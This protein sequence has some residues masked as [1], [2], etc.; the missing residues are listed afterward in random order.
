VPR[1][2]SPE[3]YLGLLFLCALPST[4]QSSI[5]FTM[6]A[7]GNVPAAVCAASASSL[8]GIVVTP[9]LVGLLMQVHGG[10][11]L[12]SVE[13]IALQLLAP[14]LV[15][16]FARRWIGDWL[17]RHK[18]LTGLVDRGVILLIVYTAFSAGVVNG[19]WHEIDLR[20]LLAVVVLDILLL[21]LVLTITTVVSRRLGFSREDEIAI[22]FCGSKK[23]LASGI[24][25]AN[26]LF[27][28]QAAS[29][30]VL[31]LILFHQIQ[32]MAC[33]ALAQSY[34]SRRDAKLETKG[35]NLEANEA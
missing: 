32:L 33:A 4:V 19:I 7:G 29:L 5:V 23:S 15:G 30:I 1:I 12:S 13:G 27:P 8:I 2:L 9:L 3:L 10:V 22:V 34:A 16:Q 31:P 6:I 35:G 14:F 18:R 25:M 28:G 17:L 11:S 24:P 21:A 26:V 20:S